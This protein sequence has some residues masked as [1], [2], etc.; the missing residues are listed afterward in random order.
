MAK[1]KSNDEKII[2]ALNAV[3]KSVRNLKKFGAKYDEYIDQAAMRGDDKRA[4]QLIR[5]KIGVYGLAEQLTTLKSNIELGA[6]TAQAV[7]DM[8]TLPDAIA[9]CKGLLSESPNFG[10]LGDSI[11][12]IFKDMQ[13][14]VEEISKLNDI[15]DG[16]LSPTQATLTSRLD[17]VDSEEENSEQFN[18]EYA[19]M[20]ERIKSKIAGESVAAPAAAPAAADNSATGAINFDGIIAEE[21]K[22]K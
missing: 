12:K 19:A 21:N 15:L 20:M 3:D 17:G 6:Y 13:K 5:Q 11:K 9:G 8:A 2:S 4:K 10:K 22:K 18:V 14:P 1:K 16:A 7:A